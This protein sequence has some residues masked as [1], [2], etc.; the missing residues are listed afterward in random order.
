M[1]QILMMKMDEYKWHGRFVIG[2]N[3][4]KLTFNAHINIH[5]GLTIIFCKPSKIIKEMHFSI[6]LSLG[7]PDDCSTMTKYDVPNQ[8]PYNV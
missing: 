8:C 7:L 2:K 6:T 4:T 3:D 5:D 1:E